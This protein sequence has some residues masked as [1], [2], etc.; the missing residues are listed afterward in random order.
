MKVTEISTGLF[1][2]CGFGVLRIQQFCKG[3]HRLRY[4]EKVTDMDPSNAY[5]F[6]TWEIF[7]NV[8]QGLMGYPAGKTNLVPNLAEKYEVVDGG[9]GY[10]FTLRSGVKFSDGSDFD[11]NVVKWTIDR[12]TRLKGD[13]SWLDTDFVD[14]VEVVDKNKV[15]FILK[16]PVAYFPHWWQPPPTTL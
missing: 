12:V 3:H 5:D 4:T 14:S 2:G 10:V 1:N 11:A 15:K 8:Y 7:Y 16:N 13:P 9:K 6:H